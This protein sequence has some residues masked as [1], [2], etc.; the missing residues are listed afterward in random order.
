MKTA[1]KVDAENRAHI[2]GLARNGR[3]WLAADAARCLAN[4]RTEANYWLIQSARCR[5]E[6]LR[7]AWR[8][9]EAA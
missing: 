2:E 7:A 3:A 9:A 4:I 6:D 1:T 5:L 8:L